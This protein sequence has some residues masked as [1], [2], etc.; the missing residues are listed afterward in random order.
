[1][2]A[3]VHLWHAAANDTDLEL[4]LKALNQEFADLRPGL[5]RRQQIVLA[6][7]IATLLLVACMLLVRWWAT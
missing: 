5:V 1:M 6:L 4:T 2:G 3:Y 7:G